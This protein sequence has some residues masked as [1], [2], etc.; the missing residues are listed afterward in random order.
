MCLR[1]R[2]QSP[3]IIVLENG[4]RVRSYRPEGPFTL[5]LQLHHVYL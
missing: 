3:H 1:E 5:P 4:R 2:G